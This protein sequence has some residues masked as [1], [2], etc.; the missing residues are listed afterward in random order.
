MTQR[1][2]VLSFSFA[3]VAMIASSVQAQ[4]LVGIGTDT[5]IGNGTLFTASVVGNSLNQIAAIDGQGSN[6]Q[7]LGWQSDIELAILTAGGAFSL[8]DLG[9]GV[10]APPNG[11]GE[12]GST[13]AVYSAGPC[14][15]CVFFGTVDNNA[16]VA[17]TQVR[18]PSFG[19]IATV[20]GEGINGGPGQFGGGAGAG[21]TIHDSVQQPDGDLIFIYDENPAN[22][23]NRRI[24]RQLNGDLA[25]GAGDEGLGLPNPG[26]S[27]VD[28]QRLVDRIV[29]ARQ[30]DIVELR[31]GDN[32][33][34][35][36]GGFT[37]SAG[38]FAAPIVD[39][40]VLSDDAVVVAA[41]NELQVRTPDLQG[42]LAG[43]GG[44][45]GT[46]ATIT[47]LAVSPV[48]DNIFIGTDQGNVRVLDRNLNQ[49]VAL[50]NY[51]NGAI[52]AL[53]VTVPEPTTCGLL[54][55]ASIG[56]LGVRRRS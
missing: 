33:S 25:A 44:Q 1:S 23:T 16:G 6:V 31:R 36:L 4:D 3:I 11:L 54:L 46:G 37:R 48:T 53:A 32:L 51:G 8:R 28:T 49:I 2:S 27:R 13:L 17:N 42:V 29:L 5:A 35:D 50:T 55:L 22:N 30:D 34:P 52:T 9:L 24:R 20:G 26:G 14:P 43:G 40:A 41:G 45:G 10:V 12:P 15:D 7:A 19:P 47:A 21:A 18:A 39:I 38:P 56:L